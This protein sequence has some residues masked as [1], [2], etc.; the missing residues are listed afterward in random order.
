VAKNFVER[1]TSPEL[2]QLFAVG[3]RVGGLL[4]RGWIGEK[5]GQGF[6]KR[7]KGP[8][9]A[10]DILVLDPA[11]FEYVPRVPVARPALDALRE[12]GVP[13]VL[14]SSNTRAEME[15][16]ADAI[17]A[18]GPLVVEN[19]G[20]VV[21]PREAVAGWP[22]WSRADGDRPVLVLGVGRDRLLAELP[23]VAAEAGV[24]VRPFAA[25][26]VGEVAA[27]TGLPEPQAALAMRREH[28]EPFVVEDLPGPDPAVDARLDRAAR[29]RGLRVTHGGRV[30]HLTG[31]ADKGQAVRAVVHGWPGGITGDV[32]GLGDAANDLELLLAVDR[33]ILI[34]RPDG[35]V[36]PALA[37]RL[38]G[39]ERAPFPGPAGWSAAVLA[40]LAGEPLPRVG[41]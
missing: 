25:M 12:R 1:T 40:A 8:G 36:E 21:A 30:H 29:H 34:P 10:S 24:R 23:A 27:L 13:L 2:Q 39:S 18:T 37:A 7:V 35:S 4:E 33:P 28:D 26:S 11:T 14:V 20:A 17:G 41:T 6:F 19:G 9:G 16:L 38:R 5:A 22:A 15:P 32:V 3:P 31:P